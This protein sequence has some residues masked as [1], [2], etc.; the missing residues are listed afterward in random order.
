MGKWSAKFVHGSM[1]PS[2]LTLFLD[3]FLKS[4]VVSRESW[5]ECVGGVKE[6]G[7]GS[8]KYPFSPFF[9]ATSLHHHLHASPR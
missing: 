9:N 4:V 7:E 3:C 8:L 2:T 6:R 5:E 1:H